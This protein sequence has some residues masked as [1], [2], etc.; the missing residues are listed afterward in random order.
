VRGG[1]RDPLIRR[2]AK[3]LVLEVWP[4]VAPTPADIDDLIVAIQAGLESAWKIRDALRKD[5]PSWLPQA[6]WET[7][8]RL[9]RQA[10]AAQG[11]EE[12]ERARDVYADAGLIIDPRTGAWVR[13][14]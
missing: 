14:R 3:Q 10:L 12:D 13:R 2:L 8:L 6:V 11:D 9:T 5:P 1:G 7:L 4:S